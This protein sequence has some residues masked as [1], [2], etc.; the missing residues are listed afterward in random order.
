LTIVAL[1][2]RLGDRLLQEALPSAAGPRVD[3]GV[4][5]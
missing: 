4:K 2:A 3:P 1:A 5:E